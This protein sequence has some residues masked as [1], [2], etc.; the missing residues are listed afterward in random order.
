MT[1]SKIMSV[2]FRPTELSPTQ[3]SLSLS[4]R[5][6]QHVEDAE[7]RGQLRGPSCS[8]CNTIE[9]AYPI[10]PQG[11]TT[12]H[13]HSHPVSRVLI[14]EPCWWDTQSPFLYYGVV[15]LWQG[16]RRLDILV[17]VPVGLRH[18]NTEGAH[19]YWNGQ[20]LKLR[21]VRGTDISERTLGRLRDRLVNLMLIPLE[22]AT[23]YFC[24]LADRKGMLILVEVCQGDDCNHIRLI[25]RRTCCV[26]FVVNADVLPTA[27]DTGDRLAQLKEH[28]SL[29]AVLGLMTR[30]VLAD[31][32][33]AI[34]FL[35]CSG[36]MAPR[37]RGLGLPLLLLGSAKEEPP[38]G[39]L[40]TIEE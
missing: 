35:V 26:G 33:Q 27:T 21:G 11:W 40:G 19:W 1:M 10:R 28:V 39:V 16:N 7:L 32:P 31:V 4:A 29:P 2:D 18:L 30:R 13:P 25:S 8:Y 36:S 20:P 22:N 34:Q 9:L 38:V 6:S 14:P 23:P 5:L 37:M 3:A 12:T 15:E 24:D 17:D